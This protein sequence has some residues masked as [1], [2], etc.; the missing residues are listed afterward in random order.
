MCDNWWLIHETNISETLSNRSGGINANFFFL[1]YSAIEDAI[2]VLKPC[3]PSPCGQFSQC[4]DQTGVAVCKC[5]PNY[6]GSPPNCRP[7]CTVNSDCSNSKACINEHCAD[8]CAGACG[9]NTLCNVINHRPNCAC[10]NGYE[11]DAFVRCHP[12]AVARKHQSITFD[13]QR[14]SNL[15]LC[16]HYSISFITI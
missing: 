12:I 8:P 2:Y 14:Y 5:V 11:G 9:L 3:A 16:A 1:I 13:V 15:I 4:T 7:E 6:Y 10:Q